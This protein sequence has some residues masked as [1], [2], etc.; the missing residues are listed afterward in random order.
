VDIGG[1]LGSA[2]AHTP[3]LG[4]LRPEILT[5]R[6]EAKALFEGP[7]DQAVAAIQRSFNLVR[8]DKKRMRV[9]ARWRLF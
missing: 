1:A 5:V 4:Y 2:A 3:V 7:S 9:S 8:Q 6:E